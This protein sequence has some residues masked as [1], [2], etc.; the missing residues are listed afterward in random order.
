MRWVDLDVWLVSSLVGG[1]VRKEGETLGLA[2]ERR[3][4]LGNAPYSG[5]EKSLLIA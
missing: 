2:S 4:C 5:G 3:Q 1:K